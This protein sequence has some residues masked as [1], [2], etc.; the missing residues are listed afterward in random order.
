MADPVCPP[1]TCTPGVITTDTD[2]VLIGSQSVGWACMRDVYYPNDSVYYNLLNL[3]Y[4]VTTRE[5]RRN[6]DCSLV[7][8]TTGTSTFT[9]SC[10][11]RTGIP[12]SFGWVWPACVI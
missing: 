3:T 2:T 4:Q 12:C 10:Q 9:Q 11:Q 1:Q 6:A 5:L 7:W 8:V